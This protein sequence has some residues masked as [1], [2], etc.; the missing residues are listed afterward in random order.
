MLEMVSKFG[1]DEVFRAFRALYTQ[2]TVLKTQDAVLILKTLK[3]IRLLT[4]LSVI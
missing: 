1:R 2:D 3:L 4:E